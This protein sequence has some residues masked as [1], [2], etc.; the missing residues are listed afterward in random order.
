MA[1]FILVHMYPDLMN[2]YGDRGNLICI[3]KRLEWYGHQCEIKSIG[4]GD[5]I[6]FEDTDMVFMGGGSDREQGLIYEDLLRK[7][8]GLMTKIE[9]GFPVLCI[10]GAYQLLG[11]YYKALD[12]QILDGL[13]W[14]N[15]Y[16]QS[17]PG[18]L[19]GNIVI[20]VRLNNT[21]AM[22]SLSNLAASSLTATVV[23]FENHGGRTYLQDKRLEPLGRVI[24]GFGNNGRD[25]GEGMR[26]RNLIGT[27]LHGPLLPK[28]PLLADEFIKIMMARRNITMGAS[29]DD[30]IEDY[31]HAEAKKKVLGRQV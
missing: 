16:T 25:G 26:Y 28:N 3:K 19:I 24:K 30:S 8:D 11:K 13:G 21:G 23:G 1:R 15:F 17:E 4:L 10:C 12:G 18:R 20:E 29:L 2:L 9:Q 7:A 6:D 5:S 31:A 14:F 27:Y 22:T